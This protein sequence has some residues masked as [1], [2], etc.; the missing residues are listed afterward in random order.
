M[1]IPDRIRIHDKAMW[2]K[3]Y[4]AFM[5]YVLRPAFANVN[6][7]ICILMIIIQSSLY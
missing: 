1:P 7:F 2:Y 4:G 3:E 6:E 5:I